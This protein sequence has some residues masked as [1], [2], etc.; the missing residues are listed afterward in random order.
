MKAAYIEG[1]GAAGKLRYGDLADPLP[2]PGEALVRVAAVAVNKVDTF[3]RSGAWRTPVGF[4]LAL[5]R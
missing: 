1:F 2:G 4:P 3:V 5:G